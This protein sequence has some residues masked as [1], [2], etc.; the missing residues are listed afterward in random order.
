MS[1]GPGAIELAIEAAFKAS[2]STLFS[3]YDLV[4]LAYADKYQP[5]DDHGSRKDW[6]VSKAHR[7]SVIRAA[8]KV[9]KRIWWEQH[10]SGRSG[11]LVYRSMLHNEH[12]KPGSQEWREIEIHKADHDERHEE[13]EAMRNKLDAQD[14]GYMTPMIS[15][16]KAHPGK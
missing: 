3:V 9:A 12:L 13:A 1:R 5:D 6:E 16:A 10:R 4:L 7:F 2:P 15:K 8:N 11:Y 14:K